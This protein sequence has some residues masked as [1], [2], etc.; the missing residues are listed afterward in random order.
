MGGCVWFLDSDKAEL[1][2]TATLDLPKLP[3]KTTLI[4]KG[5][6]DDDPEIES[7]LKES[8]LLI[9]LEPRPPISMNALYHRIRHDVTNLKQ[10]LAEKGYFDGHVEFNLTEGKSLIAVVLTVV[11]GKRYTISGMSVITKEDKADILH[12]PPSKIAKTLQLPIG[13]AVDLVHIQ[14]ANQRT[15]AFLRNHGYPYAEMS[16]PEGQID[17]ENKKLYVVFQAIPGPYSVFGK[18]EVTGLRNLA[19]QFVRNRLIWQ[20]G[21]RFDE[22]KIDQTRL[23]LMGTGLFSTIEIKPDENAPALPRVPL[24]LHAT[25]GPART[26]GAGLKYATTEG[27]GGQGFWS[28]RNL[29]GGGEML[30]ATLR[31]SPRLSKAKVDLAIPDVFASQQLLRHELSA[32]VEQNRAYTSR[33]LD[34]GVRLEHPFT[35]SI[36]GMIGM[37][38]EAGKVKR[39]NVDYLNRLIGLP[40]EMQVDGSN[41]L[42]DPTKGGRLIAQVTPYVGRSG[43]GN[44]LMIANAKGSYYL[45]VFNEE[46]TI[47]I[48]GWVR[49]GT[50]TATSLNAIAPDKRFYAGGVGSVRAYGYK[51]LGPLDTNRIPLGSRSILEYG[52][53]GRFKATDT[54]G[55]VLFAEAGHLSS[56]ATPDI[57]NKTRL[58]G[59]GAGIR[60]YTTIGPIRLDIARPMKRRRDDAGKIIDS[61]YQFYVSIGQAF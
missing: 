53:E 42:I 2:E 50:I 14:E 38:G 43:Q 11:P 6:E 41:D 9:K 20:E 8:S 15:A 25:E 48:A 22:R 52:L 13:E 26:V 61:G 59:I 28:H 23:K 40:I 54:I 60:Y 10:A 18:T 39:A 45:R 30:G 37:I 58:W 49:G 19:P 1:A 44:R 27:L 46:D 47:V 55:F 35:D 51:L 36:K 17:R 34:A 57:S 21:E 29:F 33:S 24:V 7:H 31:A 4:L 56:K 16:E 32:Y 12:L 5:K 3:Y